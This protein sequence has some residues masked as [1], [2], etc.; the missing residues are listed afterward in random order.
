MA[1]FSEKLSHT[2]LADES[3]YVQHDPCNQIPYQEN[4]NGKVF[5]YQGKEIVCVKD[6]RVHK[7]RF[8]G[9]RE[10]N[11]N[12]DIQSEQLEKELISK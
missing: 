9:F 3:K 11:G 6:K 4:V 5:D 8:L 1:R 10:K 2:K 12:L 7:M